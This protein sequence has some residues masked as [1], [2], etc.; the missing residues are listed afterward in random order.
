MASFGSML[1][2]KWQK[3]KDDIKTSKYT[4]EHD[5][6]FRRKRG[7]KVLFI[8][9]FVILVLFTISFLFPF[10]W[11]VMNAFKETSEFGL[12]MMGWPK[13]FTFEN[14]KDAFT[15]RDSTTKNM[16][17]LEMLGMTI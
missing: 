9:M 16:T 17:I 7:E 5:I 14:F 15:Y 11:I 2:K 4:R 10:A 1:R 8:V 13:H 6:L 12:N 3:K